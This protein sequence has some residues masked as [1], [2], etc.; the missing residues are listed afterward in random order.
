MTGIFIF[1]EWLASVIE[2]VLN[3]VMIDTIAERHFDKRRHWMLL[4]GMSG[5]IGA[6]VVLLNV[7]DL[8]MSIPTIFYAMLAWLIGSYILYRGKMIEFF[9]MIICWFFFMICV[10]NLAFGFTTKIGIPE[11]SI[12]N[13]GIKRAGLIFIVKST[14]VILVFLFYWLVKRVKD[15]VRVLSKGFITSAICVCAGGL[16][17]VYFLWTLGNYV[18]VDLNMFQSIFGMML[19]FAFAVLYLWLQ[20]QKEKREK[21]YTIQQNSILEK[22]YITAKESYETNAKLYHDMKNHF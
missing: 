15:R 10:D 20:M 2:T 5:L 14:Q 13:F 22:N 21:A 8:R 4:F 11:E 19:I 16:G 18:G 3:F 7:I 9:M 17:S 1:I 12:V 6:G